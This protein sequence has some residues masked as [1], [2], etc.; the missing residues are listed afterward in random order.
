[1][2]ASRIHER[3]QIA[4]S[5]LASIPRPVGSPSCRSGT[6]KFRLFRVL[7]NEGI[8][9]IEGFFSKLARSVLRHIR[10]ASK[11]ELKQRIIAA[12]DEFNRH[13]VVH[14]WSYKLDNAA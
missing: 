10:V 11:Q 14:T 5:A 4:P 3:N 13:P 12:M 8:H 1:M 9:E 2:H 7:K 6:P